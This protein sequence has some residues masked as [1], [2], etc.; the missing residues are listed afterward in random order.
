V[1][2]TTTTT[3]TTNVK[4]SDL[5]FE[6][7]DELVAQHPPERRGESRLMVADRTVGTIR[8]ERI[9]ALPE[10]VMPGTVMVFNDS[11]VRRARVYATGE[12]GKGDQEFLLVDRIGDRTWRVIG[13]HSRRLKE[14]KT[15]RFAQDTPGEC[16]AEITGIRAPYREL[17]FSIS[18]DDH[19]LDTYGHMP[20]PPYIRRSDE[21]EDVSRYQTVY[22]RTVGSVAAPT[23]GLHFTEAL[24]RNLENHGVKPHFVTLHVG[25]GT[26]LPVRTDDLQD[27]R[28]HTET[29]TVPEE[30]AQ[31]IRTARSDGAPVLAVGTTAVRTLESAVMDDGT[32]RTGS[33]DTDIFITPGY[34][35]RVVD[36]LFTNFHTPRSTLLALVCAFAGTDQTLRWYNEAVRRRYRF[37]SYGDAMLVR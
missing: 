15:Y 30:T 37:F 24:I 35:F 27:H 1:T 29:Y 17:T 21:L 10:V 34:R 16:T 18:L 20:L 11:R 13:T 8:H 2:T 6:L 22:A 32:I 26:F 25:I 9:A 3:T 14:G 31:A 23:A 7:P 19:W 28:M 12:S 33:G 36:Q 5:S 4:T